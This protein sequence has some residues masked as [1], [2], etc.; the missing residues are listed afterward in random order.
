METLAVVVVAQVH[1]EKMEIRLVDLVDLQQ[2]VDLVGVTVLVD[3]VHSNLRAVA[4][5]D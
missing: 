1:L 5:V 2:A 3:L 4:V